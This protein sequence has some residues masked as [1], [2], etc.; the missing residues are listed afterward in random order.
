MFTYSIYQSCKLY[1]YK[2]GKNAQKNS[3]HQHSLVLFFHD[4]RIIFSAT[5]R[6]LLES[7]VPVASIATLVTT[8]SVVHGTKPELDTRESSTQTV[9][10]ELC[11][12]NTALL[13]NLKLAFFW[14]LSRFGRHMDW[15]VSICR[16]VMAVLTT[17]VT[18]AN[19]GEGFV[20]NKLSLPSA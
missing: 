12:V 11:F 8:L 18:T 1:L 6:M 13:E 9:V 3:L 16:V 5:F 15:L 20:I 17:N 10:T 19:A 7:T 14:I 2:F 4:C